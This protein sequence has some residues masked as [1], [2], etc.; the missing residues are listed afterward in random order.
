MADWLRGHERFIAG[1]G[2]SLDPSLLYRKKLLDDQSKKQYSNFAK[3]KGAQSLLYGAAA[4]SAYSRFGT[5][6]SYWI[7]T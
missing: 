5:F 1:S 6:A 3:D 7:L 2:D 4:Q